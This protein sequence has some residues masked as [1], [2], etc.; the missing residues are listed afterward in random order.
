[1]LVSLWR[2]PRCRVHATYG[3][4]L[5][6]PDDVRGQRF[7][8]VVEVDVEEALE[9]DHVLAVREEKGG[10][11]AEEA[12]KHEDEADSARAGPVLGLEVAEVLDRNELRILIRR[13]RRRPRRLR[14]RR[15][16][17]NEAPSEVRH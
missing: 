17:A 5:R 2:S 4:G 16:V 13:W 12:A 15:G 8:E 6:I 9:A 10:A 14:R 7:E 3:E 11:D 1:M